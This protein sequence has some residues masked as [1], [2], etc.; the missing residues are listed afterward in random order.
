MKRTAIKFIRKIFY[1]IVSFIFE[2]GYI[3]FSKS[4]EILNNVT[5]A[6][7][8]FTSGSE[9][10]GFK[11]VFT[12][13]NF[14]NQDL[15]RA[16]KEGGLKIHMSLSSGNKNEL[17]SGP[18]FK[19]YDCSKGFFKKNEFYRYIRDQIEKNDN[20]QEAKRNLEIAEK[21]NFHD[22]VS[23]LQKIMDSMDGKIIHYIFKKVD[24]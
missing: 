5:G 7:E 1:P 12:K 15:I 11:T 14:I 8:D 23:R 2:W 4:A 16:V 9:R 6:Y 18:Y 3:E 22:K 20:F 17:N 21:N 24:K 19:K 13:E 10:S